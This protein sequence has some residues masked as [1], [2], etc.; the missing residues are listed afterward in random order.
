MG[1]KP[2]NDNAKPIKVIARIFSLNQ[3]FIKLTN[4]MQEMELFL[5]QGT[6][7]A[8]VH[9]IFNEKSKSSALN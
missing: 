3:L 9:E 4:H 1:L 8:C 2:R 5:S 7:F 6:G